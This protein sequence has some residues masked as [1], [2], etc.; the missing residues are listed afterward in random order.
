MAENFECEVYKRLDEAFAFNGFR[1]DWNETVGVF[2][3]IL[4]PHHF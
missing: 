3:Y 1:R 2:T 4:K